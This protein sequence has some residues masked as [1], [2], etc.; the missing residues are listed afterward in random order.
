MISNEITLI[1]TLTTIS[2]FFA[3]NPFINQVPWKL[4]FL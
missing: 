1:K 4:G 2:Q 3:P